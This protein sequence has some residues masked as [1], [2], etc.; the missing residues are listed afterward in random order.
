MAVD[1]DLGPLNYGPC[2]GITVCFPLV[3]DDALPT[4]FHCQDYPQSVANRFTVNM[5]HIPSF[6]T[7]YHLREEDERSPGNADDS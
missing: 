7:R 1:D 6:F 2:V 4:L 3:D 5:H